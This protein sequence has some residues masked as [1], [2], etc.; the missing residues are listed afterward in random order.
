[1]WEGVIVTV[2]VLGGVGLAIV[3]TIVLEEISDVPETVRAS[4]RG[5]GEGRSLSARVERLEARLVAA[6]RKLVRPPAG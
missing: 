6:E 5:T 4:M 3:A 2:A 1:M